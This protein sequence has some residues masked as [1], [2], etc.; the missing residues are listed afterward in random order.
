[1]W[2]ASM[3]KIQEKFT[4]DFTDGPQRHQ[5]IGDYGTSSDTIWF[6][7]TKFPG[8]PAYSMAC[9]V[10]E[11]WEKFRNDQLGITDESVDAF[12]LANQEDKDPGMLIDAPYHGPHCEGDILER[13]CIQMAGEDWTEYCLAV[14][15]LFKP[16]DKA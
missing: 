6:K 11:I 9:A 10:H 4:I 13:M 5:Q 8:H 1:M 15:N 14:D 16:G 2:R 3:A 12:D 7:I